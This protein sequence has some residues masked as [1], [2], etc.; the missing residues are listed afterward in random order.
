VRVF[1]VGENEIYSALFVNGRETRPLSREEASVLIS[2]EDPFAELCGQQTI[3]LV[4]PSGKRERR[5]LSVCKR[6]RKSRPIPIAGG[7][8]RMSPP[9]LVRKRPNHLRGR[10]RLLRGGDWRKNAYVKFLT[11]IE[12]GNH[13]EILEA[14]KSPRYRTPD[15]RDVGV[16]KETSSEPTGRSI[17]YLPNSGKLTS[18]GKTV[19]DELEE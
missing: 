6:R 3:V 16:S 15:G 1:R 9:V 4:R 18:R 8:A 7:S 14:L 11:R 5:V 12:K 19:S 10:G 2:G 17:L 13:L